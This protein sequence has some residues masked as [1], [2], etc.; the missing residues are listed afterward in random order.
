MEGGIEVCTTTTHCGGAA[1][2]PPRSDSFAG[3]E[4]DIEDGD[5][6]GYRGSVP[7]SPSPSIYSMHS[8]SNNAPLLSCLEDS[9]N[10]NNTVDES[11][12]DESVSDQ[13][14]AYTALKN[15]RL[16][17]HNGLLIAYLNINSIRNKIDFLRPMVS[18]VVDILIIAETKIDNTF[19]T[20]QFTIEGFMKPYRY[21]RDRN[22]GGLLIY[23]RERAPVKELT[24]LKTPKD[25]E[26][27][28]IRDRPQKAKMASYYQV[29]SS[30]TST[31]IL[32]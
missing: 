2:S 22:G 9:N 8:I 7:P 25:I 20:S 11:A 15:I 1:L 32:L 13:D 14:N 29:S 5:A 21:D 17:N 31:T 16:N 6:K 12:D 30:L 23:V 4:D 27:G 10:S 24:P 19:P 28:I 18:E 26:C 3:T